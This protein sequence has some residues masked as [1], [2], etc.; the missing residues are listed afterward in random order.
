[1]PAGSRGMRAD[2]TST[3]A[4]DSRPH[5][6]ETGRPPTAYLD[7]QL[8]QLAQAGRQRAPGRPHCI[9]KPQQLCQAGDCVPWVLLL[10]LE[11][12]VQD[13][14]VCAVEERD[15]LLNCT[16]WPSTRRRLMSH[17]CAS[18]GIPSATEEQLRRLFAFAASGGPEQQQRVG[19][20]GQQRGSRRMTGHQHA[21]ETHHGSI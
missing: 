5:R 1:M 9:S 16:G 13:P 10:P 14:A 15:H 17:C 20:R 21:L 8:V 19:S 2:T 18:A 3:A 12:R 11:L 6:P 7:L 4:T